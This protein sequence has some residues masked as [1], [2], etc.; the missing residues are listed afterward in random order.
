MRGTEVRSEG[1]EG[2]KLFRLIYQQS[3]TRCNLN[4]HQLGLLQLPC[5]IDFSS[6]ATW[7]QPIMVDWLEIDWIVTWNLDL[8]FTGADKAKRG[9]GTGSISIPGRLPVMLM[10]QLCLDVWFRSGS[11][12]PASP[13][14]LLSL[15]WIFLWRAHSC[16]ANKSEASIH[17]SCLLCRN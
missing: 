14:L 17:Y 15:H 2:F 3:R 10:C 9:G 16:E 12:D 5:P 6:A 7:R 13:S 4:W 11:P 1:V 8:F